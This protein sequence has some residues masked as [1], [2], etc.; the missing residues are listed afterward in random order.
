MHQ[1]SSLYFFFLLLLASFRLDAVTNCQYWVA[2]AASIEGQVDTQHTDSSDWLSVQQNDTFCPGDKIR[3]SKWSRSTLVF[4]NQSILTLDQNTTILFPESIEVNVDRPAM[5]WLINLLKGSIFFRSRDSQRLN[6]LTPF[7]NAVHEGTEFL[8]AV[9]D[10]KTEISVFD[11]QVSAENHSGKIKIARGYIGIAEEK[12]PPQ[13]QAL[14]ITPNDAVQWALYYPPIIDFSKANETKANSHMMRAIQA[15]RQG[16]F[17]ESLVHLNE[18]PALFKNT[19]ALTLKAALLLSVGRADEARPLIKQVQA[20]EPNNSEAVSLLAIIAITKNQQPKAL[21]LANKAV[22]ANPLSPV[23]KIAQ[24]YAY[25]ASYQIGAALKSTQEA[26]KL[27]PENALAWLRLSE[28]QLAQGDSNSALISAQTAQRI[29]PKLGRTQTILGFANLAKTA[30]SAAKLAFEQALNIDSSDPLAHLGLGLAKIRQGELEEGKNDLETAVNLDH[31]DAVIR[32]YLGK[33]YYELKNKTYAGTE[34]KIAKELDFKDPT[35]WFYDAI[36]KQTTNRPIEALADMQKAI[37]LNDNRGIYRSKLLLDKDKAARQAGLGRIFN[38]LG[39]DDVANRLA[40]KSLTTDPSNYSA[41]RLLSDSYA[42]KPRNE[43]ARTSEHLQSQ[44]LQPLSYNPIQ[45]SLAYTDLN[46][47]KGVGPANTSFN[48]YNRLFERNG[49]KLT[50]TGIYGSNDTIGDETALSGIFNKFSFSLGQLHY[51]TNGFRKNN[52]LKHNLYN[53]FAQYEMTPTINLQ[54]EFRHR[55]TEHGDLELKGNAE[56]FND[57]FSRQIEQDSYRYGLKIS[58]ALHSDLLFSFI[59]GTRTEAN[60]PGGI[61]DLFLKTHSYDLET[62][63]LFHTDIFNVT[64]GGGMFRTENGTDFKLPDVNISSIYNTT[65]Y[66][67]YLYSNYH[68]NNK[69]T[70]TAGLSFDH[71]RSKQEI[72]EAKINELNPK[73]GL[74]WNA[75][76]NLTFRG[77]IFKSVKSAIVD[78][79]ILQPTQIAGFNQ[80]FD[81]LNGTV[82]WLYGVGMDAHILQDFYTGIEVY[83]RDLKIPKSV[84]FNDKTRE[85]LYRLYLNWTPKSYLAV[86]TEFRLENFRNDNENATDLYPSYIETLSVPLSLRFFSPVGFFAEIK[87]TFFNQKALSINFVNGGRGNDDFHSNF[88]LVDAALGYRFPKQYGLISLEGKNLFDSN[89]LYR[90]RQFQMNEQRSPDIYPERM[91]FARVTFNF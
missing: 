87:G 18:D 14:K 56:N 33:A 27:A 89:F 10:R 24:S 23:A 61:I 77:A 47:I 79:Q 32:S 80:F 13:I 9:S 59:H 50:T 74:F 11:G 26:I 20:I 66:F 49:V 43:I 37:E 46:T 52:D 71:Y 2:K 16:H 82:A 62:Q 1:K 12:S 85:E 4:N 45:P 21:E 6:I 72:A 81:D 25:Q 67:G 41:H 54:A 65:Q 38:S 31:N 83:K 57:Q 29:N 44:L 39:F 30:I 17:S 60:H 91:L 22:T 70:L 86:N 7:I 5:Q 64:L 19:N 78:N 90:D 84:D 28:L 34:F 58:P 88:Y 55:E 69:L 40:A 35:P 42:N 48:E 68:V 36:L 3:T 53:V 75:S 8:V 76:N 15:Y 73:F 51:D 63:Y